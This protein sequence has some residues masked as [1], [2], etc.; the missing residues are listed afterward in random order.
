LFSNGAEL[1]PQARKSWNNLSVGLQPVPYNLGGTMKRV[2]GR[3]KRKYQ[4]DIW[5]K[6]MR[7]VI[8]GMKTFCSPAFKK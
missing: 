1:E 5:S 4:N 7:K 3:V 8:R 6:F 2:K